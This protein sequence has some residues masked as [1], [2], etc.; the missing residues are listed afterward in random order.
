VSDQ[1][2][3]DFEAACNLVTVLS[4]LAS[5]SIQLDE[6][7]QVIDSLAQRFCASRALT[8]LL[9]G[10]AY[11]HETYSQHIQ[12]A[13]GEVMRRIEQSMSHSLR[14][15]PQLT[16]QELLDL[17]KVTRNSKVIETAQG[18]LQRHSSKIAEAATLTDQILALRRSFARTPARPTLGEQKRQAGGLNLRVMASP[19]ATASGQPAT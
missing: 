2:D 15:K 18:I 9:G 17:G 6:V 19:A 4:L 8:E 7:Q 12:A 14:G 11:A 5:R 1:P 10:C 16:V 13:F 3:F